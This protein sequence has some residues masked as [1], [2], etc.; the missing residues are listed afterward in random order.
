MNAPLHHETEQVELGELTE[1][2]GFM[3]R[4]AQV[5]TFD[6]FFDEFSSK[7]VT[8][9]EFTV[10][11]VID[12]NPGIKQGEL[13][14]ALKIKPAHMT[15]LV[16][17]LVTSGYAARTVPENDRRSVH[18]DLTDKG[19]AHYARHRAAFLNVHRAERGGL[20]EGEASELLRL[21]RKLISNGGTDAAEH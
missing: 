17:R 8:P 3:V 14:R 16:Q 15:K 18:L 7:A 12:L 6:K 2:L 11:W 20:S 5:A 19:K 21:L 9:G 4:L 1:S 13:A 10:L